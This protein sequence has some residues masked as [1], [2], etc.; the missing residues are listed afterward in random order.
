LVK[1]R[2]PEHNAAATKANAQAGYGPNN[3]EPIR[4]KGQAAGNRKNPSP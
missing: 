3:P 1:P 4:F 2:N